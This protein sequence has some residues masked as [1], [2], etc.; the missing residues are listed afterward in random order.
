MLAASLSLR[1]GHSIRAAAPS[2]LFLLSYVD[3]LPCA[4]PSLKGLKPNTLACGKH[5]RLEQPSA[6]VGDRCV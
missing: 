5:V 4:G 1:L 2:G 3:G 6:R